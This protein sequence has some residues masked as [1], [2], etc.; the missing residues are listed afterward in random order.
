MDIDPDFTVAHV[1]RNLASLNEDLEPYLKKLSQT[2]V[3][4]LDYEERYMLRYHLLEL[5]AQVRMLESAVTEKK[6][7]KS[8]IA[9]IFKK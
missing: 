7:K 9:K 6:A 1:S 3:P 2:P 4:D 8:I 5:G